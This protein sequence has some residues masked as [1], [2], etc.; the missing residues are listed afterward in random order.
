[1]QAWHLGNDIKNRYKI[2]FEEI[3]YQIPKSSLILLSVGEIDC[4]IDEG[5]MRVIHNSPKVKLNELILKTVTNYINYVIKLNRELNHTIII[6]GVPCPNINFK[7]YNLA[8][9]RQL[10]EVIKTFNRDLREV[11]K[12]KK[13]KFLDLYNLTNDG[14]GFS[15]GLWHI[16][17]H[18]ISQG[19]MLKHQFY[20]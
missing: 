13:L 7:N 14:E 3:F 2:K 20:Q 16:D 5:I 8:R 15:N 6:Q 4:R 17:T 12:K 10:S 11:S 9:I 18:H 19:G 1:M